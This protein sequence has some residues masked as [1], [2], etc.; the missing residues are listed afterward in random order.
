MIRR[1]FLS[2]LAA[3]L[4]ALATPAAAQRTGLY[5][6]NGTNPDG[7]AYD[8]QVMMQQVGIVSW[9][10]VWSVSGERIEG[11]GMSSGNVLSVTYQLGQ[12]TGMG[13]FFINADGSMSGQW[14]VLGS[15]GIGTETLRP[16]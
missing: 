10:V 4:L 9:R 2:A 3:G 1:L 14:T 15:S 8:G 5:E 7:T 16:R 12:R 13:I 6:L 11:I